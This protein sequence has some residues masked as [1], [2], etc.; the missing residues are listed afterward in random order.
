[1]AVAASALAFV[2]AFPLCSWWWLS[3]VAAAAFAVGSVGARSRLALLLAIVVCWGAAWAW[4]Q[5]W[6]LEVSA[7]GFPALVTYLIAWSTAHAFVLRRVAMTVG[8]R[9]P[10]ALLLPITWTGLEL[11]R[12]TVLFDG[13]PWYFIGHPLIEV[14]VV[15]QSADLF[16]V[17]LMSAMVCMVGGAAADFWLGRVP[18]PWRRADSAGL[19]RATPAAAARV[20]RGRVLVVGVLLLLS[21]NVGY[22]VHRLAEGDRLAAHPTSSGPL[23][24]AI[25]TNVPQSNKV[26][27]APQQQVADFDAF[28]AL[29]LKAFSSALDQ[30]RVPDVVA[31]PETMLPGFGLEEETIDVLV[32][33]DWFPGDAFAAGVLELG[34]LLRRPLLLGSAAFEGFDEEEGRFIWSRRYNS[35]YVLD[36][37]GKRQRYD[38]VF[39]TPFGETMPYISSIPALEARLLDIGA[40][41][42]RFD[43][44]AGTETAPLRVVSPRGVWR[45]AT[46]ICFEDAVAWLCREMAFSPEGRAE[47]AASEGERSLATRWG[48]R[49]RADLFINLTNDG[50]FGTSDATRIHH[51]Q[52]ARFRCIENRL[53][54]VRC[55]NTGLTVAIDSSG[56]LTGA[57]IGDGYGASRQAGSLASGV[58]LDPR[59]P[60][61]AALG[62]LMGWLAA[63]AT[64]SLLGVSFLNRAQKRVDPA[65]RALPPITIGLP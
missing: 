25:Q 5:Q 46:P 26:A 48:R 21:L 22:G 64:A 10:L 24:L 50:W 30:A 3:P 62:D 44:D 55:V 43:L 49:K 33:G 59:I 15:A 52:I 1:L 34:Q 18:A 35:A 56:R 23:V 61:Y 27:W 60:V 20:H 58:V 6:V 53:A 17:P 19:A 41:G 4:V 54:M 51:A 9:V 45:V 42:M 39:L 2:L 16:G 8:G 7:A 13:Y 63:G 40:R 37:D 28:R 32:K 11:L 14:P 12:G 31:W 65:A 47:P 36:P 38:K 57:A 29:T